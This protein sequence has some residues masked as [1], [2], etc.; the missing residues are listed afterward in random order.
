MLSKQI[1]V[2]NQLS[3]RQIEAL[4]ADRATTKAHGLQDSMTYFDSFH[5]EVV[6]YIYYTA[7]AEGVFDP[8]SSIHGLPKLLNKEEER[9]RKCSEASM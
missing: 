5:S 9:L 7:V 4:I 8:D 1:R 3:P 2:L 6:D